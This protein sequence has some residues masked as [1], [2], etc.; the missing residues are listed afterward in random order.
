MLLHIIP[1]LLSGEAALVVGVEASSLSSSEDLSSMLS[2][3]VGERRDPSLAE[4]GNQEY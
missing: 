2:G 4:E 1:N 3:D